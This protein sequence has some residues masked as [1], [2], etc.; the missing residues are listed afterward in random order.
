MNF[1][2]YIQGVLFKSIHMDIQWI[3]PPYL[4][5]CQRHTTFMHV[6]PEEFLKAS[7]FTFPVLYAKLYGLPSTANL[8]YALRLLLDYY[9]LNLKCHIILSVTIL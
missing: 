7:P 9:F 2:I 1:F 5:F 8:P 6:V 3:G 4:L